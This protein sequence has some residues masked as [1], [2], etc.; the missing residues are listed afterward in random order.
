MSSYLPSHCNTS[1]GSNESS[2]CRLL[3]LL[4]DVFSLGRPSYSSSRFPASYFGSSTSFSFPFR[5]RWWKID[6]ICERGCLYHWMRARLRS[7]WTIRRIWICENNI[8]RSALLTI[9]GFNSVLLKQSKMVNFYEKAMT[10]VWETGG[11]ST[12]L[13]FPTSTWIIDSLSTW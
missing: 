2:D 6:P 7:K 10:D 3:Q 11:C 13:E 8:P 1:S 12:E 9:L 4:V 5:S